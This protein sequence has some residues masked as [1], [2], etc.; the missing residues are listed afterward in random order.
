[1]TYLLNPAAAMS[2]GKVLAQVAHAAVAA[3]ATGGL[4]GWVAAGCPAQVL[5]PGAEAFAATAAGP[6]VVA[7]VV[8]AGLTEVPPGTVTVVAL[9]P[10][11]AGA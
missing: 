9:A 6:G 2:S 7:R 5:A 4:E 11:A 10:V 8:D 3:A 1:V